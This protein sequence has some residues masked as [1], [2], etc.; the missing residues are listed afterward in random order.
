MYFNAKGEQNT[1]AT[2]KAAVNRAKE[3]GIKKVVVASCTGRTAVLLLDSGL[4][5]V[6]V[7]HQVGFAKPGED[8]LPAEMRQRL[9]ENG[10]A[11]LTTTHLMAG[12]D[13]ALRFQFQ[14]VYPAEIVA[15]TLRMFGQGVKVCA[16]ICGMACDAGLVTPGE[17]VVAIGGSA[18]GADTAV[19]ISPAHSQHFFKTKIREI[20]CKPRDF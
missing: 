15:T 14:G 5:I 9:Q 10:V 3:L 7:T 2:V 8:E 11:V 4:E 20:I 17:N 16:E 18:T 1:E 12:L 6:C 13:R 19:V